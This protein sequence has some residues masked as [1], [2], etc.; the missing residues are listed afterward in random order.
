MG[1]AFLV[2]FQGESQ[3]DEMLVESMIN[4][5]ESSVGAKYRFKYKYINEPIL[6]YRSYGAFLLTFLITYQHFAPLGLR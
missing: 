3:R 2:I 6:T 4:L 5:Y 1:I